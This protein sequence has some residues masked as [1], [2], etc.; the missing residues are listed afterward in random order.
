[1]TWDELDLQAQCGDELMR[2]R[3]QHDKDSL[4]EVWLLFENEHGRFPLYP[5]ESTDIE[6]S[7]SVPDTKWGPWFQRTVRHPTQ[8]L[9]V[10]LV[11]PAHLEPSVWGIENTMSS[12]EPH[13]FRTAI[14]RRAE[15]GRLVFAWSTENPPLHARYRL[16]WRFKARP[17]TDQGDEHV[18]PIETMKAMGVVQEGDPILASPARRFD[19]PAEADEASRVV[20]ELEAAIVRISEVHNF[21]KGMG[22]AAPQIGIDR[23]AALVRLPDGDTIILLNARVIE[24]SAD[25]DE[26]YEGCLSFF[27]VRGMV[28]RPLT[29]HVEHQELDGQTRIT[30]FDQGAARLVAHEIDHLDGLLYK[31]RMREGVQP[32][33]VTE[34]RGG[35]QQ[36]RY[37]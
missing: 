36:W 34:Y 22:I 24:E 21:G 15:D 6:Y 27:D 33:P 23:S 12:S 5:G 13:P 1:M 20:S 2:W 29:I 18:S 8:R 11:F 37:T 30:R 19:L 4:K 7:Y 17:A 32:I 35:G 14:D 26:Q 25:T 10:R 28:P 9:S 31:A 16:E 3:V